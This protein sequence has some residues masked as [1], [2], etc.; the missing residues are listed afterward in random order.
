M[1]TAGLAR[2]ADARGLRDAAPPVL[3]LAPAPRGEPP[4]Q[5]RDWPVTGTTTASGPG[6]QGWDD[7]GH[8]TDAGSSLYVQGSL[9]VDLRADAYD[10]FFGPQATGTDDLP[11]AAA[12]ARRII[13]ATLEA[14][15]GT[16]SADQ[17]SRWMTPA[18]RE[19][20]ARRGMLARRRARRP[21]RPPR[22]RA[23]LTC[24]PADG[25]TEVS[26]VVQADGRVRALAL[27]MSGVDG[28]WLVT[29]LE[30][31]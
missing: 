1:S 8:G 4:A 17:L 10:S 18:L 9:A 13:T 7:E 11:D 5:G 29:A 25:V 6:P 28:R 23:L 20:V 14:C 3:R 19:G 31:G 24:H 16:R 21:H 2:V 12:W 30:L 22:V 27:R 26:A 15:D